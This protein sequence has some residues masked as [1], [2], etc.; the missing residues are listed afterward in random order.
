MDFEARK[1]IA[2][3]E[4]QVKELYAYVNRLITAVNN[5]TDLLPEPEKPD[6]Q[7]DR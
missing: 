5:L 1:R 4:G 2:H 7:G 6:D 3:L